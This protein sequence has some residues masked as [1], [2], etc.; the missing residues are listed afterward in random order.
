MDNSFWLI[1]SVWVTVFIV[2]H[3]YYYYFDVHIKTSATKLSCKQKLLVVVIRVPSSSFCRFWRRPQLASGQPSKLIFCGTQLALCTVR[4]NSLN[5]AKGNL[6]TWLCWECTHLRGDC[7]T[8]C[9]QEQQ[10]YTYTQQNKVVKEKKIVEPAH[11]TSSIHSQA[12]SRVHKLFPTG[13]WKLDYGACVELLC[14][15]LQ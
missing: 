10:C 12:L 8:W 11:K 9:T 6:I 4:Q 14:L 13:I 15:K 2:Y 7:R 3:Y 1:T 5:Q